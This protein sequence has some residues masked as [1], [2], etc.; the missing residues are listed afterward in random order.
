MKTAKNI[1]YMLKYLW[2]YDK[3]YIPVSCLNVLVSIV[4]PVIDIYLY[5]ML[6]DAITETKSVA[7]VVVAIVLMLV[8]N[9]LSEL[10]QSLLFEVIYPKRE[11]N[12]TA[13]MH[14]E[15]AQKALSYDIECYENPDFFDTYVKAANEANGRVLWVWG[16]CIS[17][18]S[19]TAALVT[20]FAITATIDIWV[21]IFSVLSVLLGVLFE[22]FTSKSKV[23]FENGRAA[24]DREKS[25]V[26]R[27]I[28][29]PSFI[30]DGKTSTIR[31][32]F[33][34][35][36]VGSKDKTIEL[37]N[38]YGYKIVFYGI[39]RGLMYSLINFGT[40]MYL[41]IRIL[42]STMTIGTF[43]SMLN[44]TA[45]FTD[46]LR[47][48]MNTFPDFYKHSLF[49]DNFRK[50]MEYEPRIDKAGG[51]EV[52]DFRDS[53]V[54]DNVSFKYAG[55]GEYALKNVSLTIKKGERVAIV[56]EN[57]AGKTTLVKLLLR[58]YEPTEGDILIDGVN[59]R[60]INAPSLRKLFASLLQDYSFYSA[61]IAENVKMGKA[62][63]DD[64]DQIASALAKAE[65]SAK[66]SAYETGLKTPATKEFD[67]NGASFSG[68]EKQR[69]A[70]ARVYYSD[71][72]ILVLDEANSALD[73]ISERKLDDNILSVA[74][75]KTTIFISHRLAYVKTA[76]K[77]HYIENGKI[78]ES[79]NHQ[80]LINQNQKYAHMYNLQ[81]EKYGEKR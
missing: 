59:Y 79:G 54:F 52:S 29:L 20:I 58:F 5:K 6:I 23:H 56:G 67:D 62:T 70:L 71:A 55:S 50:F 65:L 44:A 21:L 22:F 14:L 3:G 51:I 37:L 78:I 43:T 25:Y 61:T 74:Q 2:K 72:D 32:V 16:T 15:V 60:Y 39:F 80:S 10:I 13:K 47:L 66:I 28:Y 73:P 77:I 48:L 1:I 24:A 9:L 34:S 63:A 19:Y 53:I 69:L 40:M 30:Y 49:T 64:D 12:I 57:G 36:I 33:F 35:K 18:V 4:N 46:N 45:R 27:L 17:L 76:D 41:A 42:F 31:D 75:S 26:H 11:A 81:A 8:L 68:G 38:K 7:S